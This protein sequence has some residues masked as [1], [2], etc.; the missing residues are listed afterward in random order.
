M[1]EI[2]TKKGIRIMVERKFSNLLLALF[3]VFKL[4]RS[5]EG[6]FRNFYSDLAICSHCKILL[7]PNFVLKIKVLNY[8]MP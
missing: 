1:V 5:L 8:I 3:L 7:K 4:H 6:N 2:Y